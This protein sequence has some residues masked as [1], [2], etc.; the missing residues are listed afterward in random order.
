[1]RPWITLA[2][3]TLLYFASVLWTTAQLPVDGVPLHFAANGVADRLG[4]RDETIWSNSASGAL[5]TLL[6]AGVVCY[7]LRGP[8]NFAKMPHEEYWSTPERRSRFLRMFAGDLGLLMSVL[9]VLMSPVPLASAWALGSDPPAVSPYVLWAPVVAL[10]LAGI[11]WCIW[12]V[13]V[14]YDP[15]RQEQLRRRRALRHGGDDEL[16]PEH[17]TGSRTTPDA[18]ASGTFGDSAARGGIT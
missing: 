18:H 16:R 9:L 8:L 17:Q 5:M 11:A 13:A 7:A 12:L 14:R 10:H 2:A 4:T 1:M 6:G 3:G 15:E